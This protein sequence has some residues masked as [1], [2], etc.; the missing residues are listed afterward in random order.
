[1]FDT[2]T[3]VHTSC[4]RGIKKNLFALLTFQNRAFTHELIAFYWFSVAAWFNSD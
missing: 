1:M 3:A 4:V 2:K